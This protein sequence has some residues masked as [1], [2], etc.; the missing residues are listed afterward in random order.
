MA[1]SASGPIYVTTVVTFCSLYAAQPIQPLFQTEF[2]LTSIQAL[3]FTTLMMAPLGIAPLFYGYLLEAF[4]ARTLV[5]YALACLG[6]MEIL[7]SQANSYILL[8]TIRAVQGFLIPAILTSI[9]S[10]ISYTSSRE[11]V[12]Q[13][14]AF[15]IGATILGGFLGRLLS[16]ICTD[17]FGWRLFFFMLGVMLLGS[18]VPLG[19]MVRDAK[20]HYARP[21]P[22]EVLAI[23]K[24]RSFVMLY[25]AIFCLFFV[26]AALMNFV[27][28]ELRRMGAGGG[29]TGVGLIYSGYSMGILVALNVRRI[30]LFFKR[31]EDAVSIG[32]VIFAC[33]TMLFWVGSYPVM[34]CGMFVFCGGLFTA[35]SL[36][37]GYVNTLSDSNRAIA[38]GLYISFYYTGGTL[39]SILPQVVYRNFG[40]SAFIGFLLLMIGGALLLV[41]LLR[42]AVMQK[43]QSS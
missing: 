3:L 28:F 29:E 2:Q 10:Y 41:R 36:L 1:R 9:M 39:G 24:N 16:G 15:Y 4:P 12:Q 40:W 18:V 17:L 26:F 32:I 43:T 21:R 38:N 13:R 33:G 20:T 19:A 22:A 42:K 34:F 25:S 30:L 23:L 6:V 8:L 35:H 31:V 5:R 37:S 27:P 14:I 7:F 11:Q